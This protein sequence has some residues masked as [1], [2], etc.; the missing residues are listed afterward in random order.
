MCFIDVPAV[1]E[2]RDAAR[3]PQQFVVAARA[4]PELVDGAYQP[5]LDFVVELASLLQTAVVEMGIETTLA[6][7]LTL[8]RPRYSSPHHRAGFDTFSLFRQ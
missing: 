1:T 4:E 7:E 8:A 2:I 6:L 3:E 5:R